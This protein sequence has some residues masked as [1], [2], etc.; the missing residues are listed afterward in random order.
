MWQMMGCGVSVPQVSVAPVPVLPDSA[1]TSSGVSAAAAFPSTSCTN[2]VPTDPAIQPPPSP[3]P[4]AASPVSVCNGGT[5]QPPEDDE[6]ANFIDSFLLAGDDDYAE[7]R[8]D[9]DLAGPTESDFT[10]LQAGD[11]SSGGSN[12]S[13][14][15]TDEHPCL[16]RSDSHSLLSLLGP[17]IGMS[18][19]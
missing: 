13:D 15:T 16:N 19:L 4:Q 9:D 11:H 2:S 8:G 6:F 12:C 5:Q 18:G 17:D 10:R 1:R 3:P 7:I 14:A